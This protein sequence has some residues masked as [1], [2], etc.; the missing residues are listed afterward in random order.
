MKVLTAI[1]L[2]A[3]V[4]LSLA[5]DVDAQIACVR[6]PEPQVVQG[7]ITGGDNLQAGRIVRE[8]IERTTI[9]P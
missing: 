9:G 4:Y 8:F 3:S 1:L 6:A 2:I 7:S 5:L